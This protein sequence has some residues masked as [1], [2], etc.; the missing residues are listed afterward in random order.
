MKRTLAARCQ[1]VVRACADHGQYFQTVDDL[2]FLYSPST[3]MTRARLANDIADDLHD[4]IAT[5]TDPVRALDTIDTI[6]N[7]LCLVLDPA[8]AVRS[9]H[10]HAEHRKSAE[11]AFNHVQKLAAEL[12]ES[13]LISDVLEECLAPAVF[14]GLTASQQRN[15]VVMKGDFEAAGADLSDDCRGALS[16]LAGEID[17]VARELAQGAAGEEKEVALLRQL[18]DARADMAGLLGYPSYA[19]W[20]TK[21]NLASSPDAVWSF[22]HEY[23]RSVQRKAHLELDQ[24]ALVRESVVKNDSE[25]S[26]ADFEQAALQ[27][28]YRQRVFGGALEEAKEYLSAANAWRGVALLCGELFGVDMRPRGM[29]P[30]E[31]Y[32]PAVRRFDLYTTDVNGGSSL[33]GTVYADLLNRKTKTQTPSHF[34]VRLGTVLHPDV[35]RDVDVELGCSRQTP[36]VIFSCNARAAGG[37]QD[38]ERVPLSHPEV[39]TLFHEFG[40]ALHTLFG[41]AECHNLAGTRSSL[42]YVEIFSQLFEFFAFD[43]RCLSRFAFHRATGEAMPLRLAHEIRR[44]THSFAGLS[45]IEQLVLSASDLALH[46]PRPLSFR[47]P[48]G[49]AVSCTPETVA[50]QLTEVHSPVRVTGLSFK[51]PYSLHHISGYP[52]AFYSYAYSKVVAAA[53]WLRCFEADPFSKAGGAALRAVLS[54]ASSA[55]APDMLATVLGTRSDPVGLLASPAL[56]QL[57]FGD[58]DEC[59]VLAA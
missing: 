29:Y 11:K 40:H 3:I 51:R 39:V 4:A 56:R 53:I 52:A 31:Q 54:L 50:R 17:E 22:I 41:R 34:T 47:T 14:G 44:E 13:A 10:P 25:S 6:S 20:A 24:L 55:P 12:N 21:D 15:V 27:G 33:L 28:I 48:C 1:A 35:L 19:A 5:G 9:T 46:G 16:D 49:D 26:V 2:A 57:L 18:L 59:G 7:V 58:T 23:S 43:P 45:T 37:E 38:W 36:V 42:D 32:D 8:E 30:W